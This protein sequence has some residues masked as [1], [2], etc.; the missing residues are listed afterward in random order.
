LRDSN[1]TVFARRSVA[2]LGRLARRLATVGVGARLG[3]PPEYTGGGKEEER[4][5]DLLVS[6]VTDVLEQEGVPVRADPD[7]M[8]SYAQ[9]LARLIAGQVGIAGHG[10][11]LGS[12]YPQMR[13]SRRIHKEGGEV[14]RP[15]YRH[16]KAKEPDCP[17]EDRLRRSKPRV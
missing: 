16:T 11:S 9:M 14:S 5:L 1:D 17:P 15:N 6:D 2:E 4:Q 13:R 7:P 3:L 8:N 12:L 10:G